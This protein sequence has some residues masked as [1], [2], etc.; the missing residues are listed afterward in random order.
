[1]T[2]QL[3]SDCDP[4]RERHP[5]VRRRRRRRRVRLRLRPANLRHDLQGNY[6]D[7]HCHWH[8]FISFTK[9]LLLTS[10]EIKT[11]EVRELYCNRHWMPQ[12]SQTDGVHNA[13][14]DLLPLLR[15][16]AGKV[17]SCL[18]HELNHG[19]FDLRKWLN[20]LELSTWVDILEH[21]DFLSAGK[22][23]VGGSQTRLKFI[24]F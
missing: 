14:S 8:F 13:L 7:I 23:T 2:F 3:H 6:S 24:C 15:D 9:E 17:W 22:V 12:T 10:V 4:D 16:T 19:M 1:M 5:V 18:S 21:C 20:F 11:I